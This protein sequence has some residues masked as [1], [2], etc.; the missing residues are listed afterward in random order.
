MSNTW[1]WVS[2][3]RL[4]CNQR[5]V[6]RSHNL[7]LLHLFLLPPYILCLKIWLHRQVPFFSLLST[8]LRQGGLVHKSHALW[9]VNSIDLRTNNDYDRWHVCFSNAL[10]KRYP[11]IWKFTHCQQKNRQVISRSWQVGMRTRNTSP[12]RNGFRC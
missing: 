6:F 5:F 4:T 7:W 11:S 8:I 12:C 9:N 3:V 2:S 1:D 10:V